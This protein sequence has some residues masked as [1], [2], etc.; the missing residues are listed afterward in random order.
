MRLRPLQIQPRHA[1]FHAAP[2]RCLFPEFERLCGYAVTAQVRPSPSCTRTRETHLSELFQAV[3]G[4][5]QARVVASRNRRAWRLRGSL[6]RS[7]GHGFHAL[8]AVGLVTDCGVPRCA[9]SAQPS[10]PTTSRAARWSP[11]EFSSWCVLAFPFK[12]SESK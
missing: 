1:G 12:F 4:S 11:R 5:P 9:G 6:R 7:H 3:R 2:I 10:L 8:G